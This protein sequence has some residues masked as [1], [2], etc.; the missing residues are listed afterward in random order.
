MDKDRQC[1]GR[2]VCFYIKHSVAYNKRTYLDTQDTEF[3][4][5]DILLP[6]NINTFE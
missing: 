6:K 2:G 4:A 3:L 5:V 1:D